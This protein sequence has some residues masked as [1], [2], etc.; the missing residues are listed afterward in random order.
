[1]FC[2]VVECLKDVNMFTFELIFICTR[3]KT[4]T[5]TAHKDVLSIDFR[6]ATSTEKRIY[7]DCNDMQRA[8]TIIYLSL[9]HRIH[10]E[11]EDKRTDAARKKNNFNEIEYY[12]SWMEN[13]KI[14]FF[15][16]FVYFSI[17]WKTDNCKCMKCTNAF[18][19]SRQSATEWRKGF[20][21]L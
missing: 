11:N 20:T 19:L 10:R 8:R 1:M 3:Q 18:R 17:V 16:L 4:Y 14:C 7:D 6:A 21:K 15:L 12:I 13:R 2:I 5:H 9:L